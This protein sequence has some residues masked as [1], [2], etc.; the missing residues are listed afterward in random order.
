MEGTEQLAP[1]INNWRGTLSRLSAEVNERVHLRSLA[2][3]RARRIIRMKHVCPVMSESLPR[4][5]KRAP[6]ASKLLYRA[7]CMFWGRLADYSRGRQ[8]D[9]NRTPFSGTVAAIASV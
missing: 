6:Q 3:L 4:I 2:P 5:S 9:P 1:V 7:C 8:L